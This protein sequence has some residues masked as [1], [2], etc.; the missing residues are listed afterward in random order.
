MVSIPAN[1]LVGPIIPLVMFFGFLTGFSGFVNQY[2]SL[3]FSYISFVLVFYII[4]ITEIFSSL[5]FAAIDISSFS[6]GLTVIIY[7]IY[8]VVVLKNG[9]VSAHNSE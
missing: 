2:L 8:L 5:S 9:M 6:L 4:K 1:L 3:V 7:L